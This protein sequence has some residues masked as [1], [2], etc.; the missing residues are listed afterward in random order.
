MAEESFL[1]KVL[2]EN[3]RSP[4]CCIIGYVDSGKTKLLDCI[5]GIT[6]VQEGE[7]RG[8]HIPAEIILE[9]TK[10]LR[11][12]AKLKVPGL[13]VIDTPGH[14]SFT[15][16]CD[17]AILVVDIMRGL[18]PQTLESLHLL[19][20]SNVKF[21]VALNKVD[22]ICGW[23]KSKNAPLLKTME[24]Q[25]RDVANEFDMRLDH[26]KTQ[27]Q[28]QGLS[29]EIYYKNREMGE[30]ICI[31]PTSAIS[32]EGIPDLLLLLVLWA[33][34]TMVEKLTYVDKVQCTVLE[35]K[36]I[37]GHG[38]TVDVVLVNGVLREGDQ[39]VVR[40]SQGP[41]VTT[42]RSL[43]TP[44]PMNETRV[45]GTYMANREVKAAQGIIIAAEGLEHAIAGTALHVI[46]PNEDME[47]AKKNAMA[48]DEDMLEEMPED[49]D[50][51]EEMPE[52][53]A[54]DALEDIVNE[55]GDAL[56]EIVEDIVHEE[57]VE[58]LVGVHNIVAVRRAAREKKAR[59]NAKRE[60]SPETTARINDVNMRKAALTKAANRQAH[61]TNK[62]NYQGLKNAQKTIFPNK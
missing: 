25:S 13:L 58:V 20:R 18:E 59:K 47:E 42:I 17:L 4:I 45:K 21:L 29:S 51:L 32:G 1:K 38:I 2:E 23:E 60:T 48:Y 6:T 41:I 12:G 19:R 10:E 53:E 24:Q 56:E 11:A 14:E 28:E 22:T 61:K 50:M 52:D 62:G 57:A 31:V 44:Y 3:L 34:K 36:G 16:F 33:Q 27:F 30:T 55:A 37:E 5:R 40:G 39:I 15:N 46:G 8:T 35:V 9:R 26:V 43:L 49:E 54:G 7:A